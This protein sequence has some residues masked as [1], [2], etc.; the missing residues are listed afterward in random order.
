MKNQAAV[1]IPKLHFELIYVNTHYATRETLM[2]SYTSFV[3]PR[4]S[5]LQANDTFFNLYT[6]VLIIDT[7]TYS[8]QSAFHSDIMWLRDSGILDKLKY[9]IIIP[10]FP[11]LDPKVRRD[12]PLVMYQLGIIMIVLA[13]G[14]ILSLLVFF[15]EL[16]KSRGKKNLDE[17]RNVRE[18]L[19]REDPRSLIE[20]ANLTLQIYGRELVEYL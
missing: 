20:V 17:V 2:S 4:G 10:P 12:Q 14:L 3:V 11:I 18:P 6:L 7:T 19:E 15:C 8:F 13:V 1:G 16:M 5:P 9:D